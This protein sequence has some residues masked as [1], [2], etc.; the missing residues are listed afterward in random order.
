VVCGL[1]A[2]LS[3]ALAAVELASVTD[4]EKLKVPDSAVVPEMTPVVLSSD[5]PWGKDPPTTFHV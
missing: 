5:R 2:R 3:A 1:I 4:A